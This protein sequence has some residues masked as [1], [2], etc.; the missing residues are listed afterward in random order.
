LRA[1]RGAPRDPDLQACLERLLRRVGRNGG[2]A[3]PAAATQE[4]RAMTLERAVAYALEGAQ[5]DD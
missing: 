2:A 4:G 5:D 1:A 3:P